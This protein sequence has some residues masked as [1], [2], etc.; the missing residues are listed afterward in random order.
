MEKYIYNLLTVY[1]EKNN[2]RSSRQFGFRNG[3]STELAAAL[4][5]DDVHRAMDRGELTGAIF[6][7]LSKAFETVSHSVLV[8]KLSAYGIYGREK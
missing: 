7:D 8:S 2:L 6:I 5:F 1:L 3:K 4:F